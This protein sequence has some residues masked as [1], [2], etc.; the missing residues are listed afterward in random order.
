[1]DIRTQLV[2]F[3]DPHTRLSRA[4]MRLAVKQNVRQI[5]IDA[6]HDPMGHAL[7]VAHGQFFWRTLIAREL[8]GYFQGNMAQIDHIADVMYRFLEK[9]WLDVMARSGRPGVT[10]TQFLDAI[11]EISEPTDKEIDEAWELEIAGSED[12]M[13]QMYE[14]SA[15]TR[16]GSDLGIKKVLG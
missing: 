12:A 1:M 5:L 6:L 16:T 15:R 10:P 4:D 14:G 8:G 11:N 9:Q 3:E 13:R 2:G 7:A